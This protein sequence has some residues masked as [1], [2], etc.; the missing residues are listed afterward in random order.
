MFNIV[1]SLINDIRNSFKEIFDQELDG[2]SLQPTRKE[3]PGHYT[4][5]M[6]PYLKLTG[7]KPEESG[8]LL[9]AQ[10]KAKSDWVHDYNVVKGF[11][12]LEIADKAWIKVLNSFN[13]SPNFGFKGSSDQEIMVE[14]SSPNTNKPL[15]LGHLRNNF[16]GYSVARILEANG[17][18]V[19]KVQIIN[20]R[21]IHIC[22]SMVAWQKFGNGETPESTGLKGD[23][24]VGNYYVLFNKEYQK[25][26]TGLIEA[27]KSQAEAEK[28]APIML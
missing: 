27:G 24:L 12:N 9:G 20:N 13:N 3:F 2:I 18:N 5:V 6:F 10:L 14:F 4:L 23:K 8:E 16:L 7:K 11:L 1:D 17:C 26:V 19:H 21:G 28:E 15:H 25:Q 22:K